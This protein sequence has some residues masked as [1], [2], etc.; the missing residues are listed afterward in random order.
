MDVRGCTCPVGQ[1]RK[2]DLRW[3]ATEIV[4]LVALLAAIILIGGLSAWFKITDKATAA[5]L[6]SIAIMLGVLVWTLSRIR[7]KPRP[8][9]STLNLSDT[10][11]IP[12]AA[13]GAS[14]GFSSLFGKFFGIVGQFISVAIAMLFIIWIGYGFVLRI[15][16]WARRFRESYL[17]M[18]TTPE[19]IRAYRETV[20]H[21]RDCLGH[22][23]KTDLERSRKAAY[24]RAR[25]RQKGTLSNRTHRLLRFTAESFEDTPLVLTTYASVAGLVP[26]FM[27]DLPPGPVTASL[28]FVPFLA[29][30]AVRA[31]WLWVAQRGW[32]KR[33]PN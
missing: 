2:A 30:P 17:D 33:I 13:V 28:L 25:A 18:P 11:G 5:A 16:P 22:D 14:W 26:N 32:L 20:L 9:W 6:T 3:S 8:E 12:L 15:P 7:N 29:I 27:Q 4:R 23:R 19:V 24:R 1:R 10:W 21:R 31:S